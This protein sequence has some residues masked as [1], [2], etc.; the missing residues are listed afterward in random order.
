MMCTL[1]LLQAKNTVYVQLNITMIFEINLKVC[2]F[3]ECWNFHI[4]GNH[5][6]VRALYKSFKVASARILGTDHSFLSLRSNLSAMAQFKGPWTIFIN[7]NPSDMNS[8][9]MFELAGHKYTFDEDDIEGPP[10]GR[11]NPLNVRRIVAKSPVAAS[12]FFW[13]YLRCFVLTYLGWDM[14]L[15]KKIGRGYLGDVDAYFAKFETGKRGVIHAHSQA[16]QVGLEATRLRDHL[17]NTDFRSVLLEFLEHI[18]CMYLPQ[19]LHDGHLPDWA[20]GPDGIL[21]PNNDDI[22]HVRSNKLEGKPYSATT[23]LPHLLSPT[24]TLPTPTDIGRAITRV[25]LEIQTHSHTPTCD[26]KKK[27]TTYIYV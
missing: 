16:M 17:N 2:S 11:P 25:V 24:A 4:Q 14:H 7:L 27:G 1:Y 15:K 22:H 26:A 18:M 8:A 3:C 12:N 19:P 20:S 6:G 23:C 10:I 13:T 9:L 5:V 21:I